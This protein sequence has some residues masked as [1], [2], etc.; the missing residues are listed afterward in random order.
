MCAFIAL[1][2]FFCCLLLLG[3]LFSVFSFNPALCGSCP[4]VTP[5]YCRLGDLLC[6]VF[7][8]MSIVFFCYL[9]NVCVPSV[10]WYCWL[11]LLTCK[12]VSHITHA[13]LVETLNTAPSIKTLTM[14]CISAVFVDKNCLS[15]CLSQSNI[16][17]TWCD[18]TYSQHSFFTWLSQ[19]TT[20]QVFEHFVHYISVLC[21]SQ[22]MTG[23]RDVRGWRTMG[24]SKV[25]GLDPQE[26]TAPPQY[27]CCHQ[28]MFCTKMG[29]IDHPHNN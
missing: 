23:N 20:I 15:V 24:W 4:L 1:L 21:R 26:G 29:K 10:L 28:K 11:G 5:Y 25:W 3:L 27:G 7:T 19:V 9:C 8:C 17:L 16:V 13:V 2:F 22:G 18:L 14:L 6:F 12:T